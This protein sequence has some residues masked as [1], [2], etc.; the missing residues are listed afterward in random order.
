MIAQSPN[1]YSTKLQVSAVQAKMGANGP[2]LRED[3]EQRNC[4]TRRV[5]Q[6]LRN[7]AD[8]GIQVADALEYAHRH[9]IVHRDIKPSNLMIDHAGVAWVMDFGL[10]K[11]DGSDAL[12][13]TGDVLGT[14]RYMSPEQLAGRAEARSDIYSLGMTLY[15]L[16]TLRPA[17]DDAARTRLMDRIRSGTPLPPRSLEPRIP[18]DLDTILLKMIA[19]EPQDRYKRAEEAAEDLRAFLADRPIAARRAS[20]S[21]QVMRWFRRN[22]LVAGLTTSIALLLVLAAVASMVTAS[23]LHRQ[24]NAAYIAREDARRRL[25]QSKTNE[26]KA[27]LFS[28]RPGQRYDALRLVNESLEI[29]GR[30]QLSDAELVEV[31]SVAASAL[32]KIDVKVSRQWRPAGAVADGTQH[33]FDFDQHLQTYV[34]ALTGGDVSL[35]KVDGDRELHRFPT[36]D[37]H[38]TVALSA[39]G[40]WVAVIDRGAELQRLQIWDVTQTP[41]Q[42]VHARTG[43]FGDVIDFT[44][45]D[46]RAAY[47]CEQ[48]GV[49][50]VN[51]EA[52]TEEFYP[53]TFQDRGRPLAFDREGKRLA[54]AD[55]A[56]TQILDVQFNE[57]LTRFKLGGDVHALGWH[58]SGDTLAAGLSN[59]FIGL[60]DVNLQLLLT[61]FIGHVSPGITL[62]FNHRGDRLLSNDWSHRMR[63]WDV[64]ARRELLSF[65]S[66][67]KI[68][69]FSFDD[70]TVATQSDSL[71]GGLR[72]I[73]FSSSAERGTV[74]QPHGRRLAWTGIKFSPVDRIAVCHIP[75]PA[76]DLRGMAIVSLDDGVTRSIVRHPA[77]SSIGFL[78]NGSLLSQ[79]VTGIYL[80]PR[81]CD[82]ETGVVTLGPPDCLFPDAPG[83][84]SSAS[85][86]GAVLAIPESGSGFM[87]WRR[88]QPEMRIDAGLGQVGSV[89]VAPDGRLIAVVDASSKTDDDRIRIFDSA[90]GTLLANLAASAQS[91]VSFSPDG[92]WLAAWRD[93]ATSHCQIWRVGQWNSVHELDAL[94]ITFDAESSTAVASSTQGTLALLDPDTQREFLRLWFSDEDTV[95]GQ[96]YA[97][98]SSGHATLLLGSDRHESARM[99]DLRM[100][101]G[102]LAALGLDW[103]PTEVPSV[104]TTREPRVRWLTGAA[105]ASKERP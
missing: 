78:A 13:E 39:T 92:R 61:G 32:T 56:T 26:A 66:P 46:R 27:V 70:T 95:I 74:R 57:E 44:G 96:C 33:S 68:A 51:L 58:P 40:H 37:L 79:G 49:A 43:A 21:D 41:P 42:S 52:G 2:V 16:A 75:D 65:P 62:T 69:R 104:P 55:G 10:A 50:L 99:I 30:D 59:E 12:T 8:I 17:F 97:G 6:Y 85:S 48:N 64:G 100:I 98:F 93:F 101:R 105:P 87:V 86:D 84:L 31:R 28:R 94:R 14:L 34:V 89:A 15:E 23:V 1:G 38:P 71:P 63:I 73:R 4:P 18:Q 11:S 20:L 35:R 102:Q 91:L 53:T 82:P 60:V 81:S 54:F 7:V 83:A 29:V 36:A 22:P 3:W 25:W 103:S 77:Y 5:K 24:R 72:L 90:S 76:R 67:G 9:G 88:G 45:D 19:A 47:F 80:W